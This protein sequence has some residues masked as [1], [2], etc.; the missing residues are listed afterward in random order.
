MTRQ[1]KSIEQTPEELEEKLEHLKK[2]V[3]LVG[4]MRSFDDEDRQWW[5]NFFDARSRRR[6][7]LGDGEEEDCSVD[8]AAAA[9]LKQ[10]FWPD[11]GAGAVDAPATP[12]ARAVPDDEEDAGGVADLVSSLTPRTT[13]ATD[14]EFGRSR[15]TGYVVVGKDEDKEER[16]KTAKSVRK[17]VK[18]DVL[19]DHFERLRKLRGTENEYV[20]KKLKVLN[21][22][23]LFIIYLSTSYYFFTHP[24]Y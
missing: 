1:S 20:T 6:G 7:R 15:K 19:K 21:S 18:A 11:P 8:P 17:K 24:C 23:V 5:Q 4:G 3:A 22:K 2:T 14:K 12:V 10:L 13:Q 16:F 9:L